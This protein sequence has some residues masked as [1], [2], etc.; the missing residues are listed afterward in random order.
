MICPLI[1]VLVTFSIWKNGI[2]FLM[3]ARQW[4]CYGAGESYVQVPLVATCKRMIIP[5]F[6]TVWESAHSR[7][8]SA[9]WLGLTTTMTLLLHSDSGKYLFML[10]WMISWE[11]RSDSSSAL[12]RLA[13]AAYWWKG[14]RVWIPTRAA[15]RLMHEP[16]ILDVL[17]W[18]WV[19]SLRVLFCV[20]NCIYVFM[21]V[22]VF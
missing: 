4:E 8:P 14:G 6:W 13:C 1:D 16:G 11:R 9:S 22:P 18:R 3:I 5:Q 2:V 21:Y 15:A 19:R 10:K 17:F 7:A 20:P 12:M